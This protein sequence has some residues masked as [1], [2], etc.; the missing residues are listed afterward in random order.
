MADILDAPVLCAWCNA[1]PWRPAR[2]PRCNHEPRRSSEATLRWLQRNLHPTLWQDWLRSGSHPPRDDLVIPGYVNTL[3]AAKE[4]FVDD[5]PPEPAPSTR[6]ALPW[7]DEQFHRTWWGHPKNRELLLELVVSGQLTRRKRQ[8]EALAELERLGWVSFRTTSLLLL[9]D[10]KRELV[11]KVLTTCWPGWRSIAGLLA[12]HG[13]P[14]T[15]TGLR[16]LQAVNDVDWP[17]TTPSTEGARA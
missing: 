14:P 12:L 11:T 7:E 13:L 8:A 5:Q 9:P 4:A 3:L 17:P 2:C 10:H 6:P 1:E 16:Q 15:P